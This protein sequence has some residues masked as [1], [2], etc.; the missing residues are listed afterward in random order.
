MQ[1]Y[2]GN[3]YQKVGNNSYS[4]WSLINYAVPQGSISDSILSCVICCFRQILQVMLM[5]I[6]LTLKKNKYEVRN[7]S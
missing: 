7:K 3:W 5:I 1:N 2:L 4:L 6:P